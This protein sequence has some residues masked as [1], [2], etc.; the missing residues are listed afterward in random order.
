MAN[1]WY[2]LLELNAVDACY[3]WQVF[4]PIDVLKKFTELRHLKV[5]YKF[6]FYKVSSPPSPSSLLKLPN[7]N[8]HKTKQRKAFVYTKSYNSVNF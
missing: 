5:K 8:M 3:A 6:V 4:R 7:H 2:L 1:F